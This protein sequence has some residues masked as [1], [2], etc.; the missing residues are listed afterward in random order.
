[1]DTT[2]RLADRLTESEPRGADP[3]ASAKLRRL[4]LR[5]RTAAVT[6]VAAQWATAV[7]R[8]ARFPEEAFAELRKQRL[9]GIMI[10]PDLG[11]EGASLSEIVDVCYQLGQACSST[12]MIFAM[13][14]ACLACLLRHGHDH[15]WH[16]TLLRRVAGDQLLLASSTTEGQGGGNVRASAAPVEHTD[17]GIRLERAATVVSYGERADAILT[18]ARRSAE[19][20]ASDQV[21]VAFLKEDYTLEPLVGWDSLGMRGT[22]SSGFRLIANGKA[23]QI[24]PEP[25]DRIHPQ[26]M[27][28]VSHLAWAGTWAGIAA[29]AVERA[30]AFVRHAARHSGGNMPPGAAHFTKAT[31]SLR[32]LRGLIASSLRAYEEIAD[33]GKSLASLDFQAVMNL[34][35]VEASELAVSIV[36]TTMKVC[37]LSGYRNDTEFSVGRALRDVL[38]SPIMISNDR[39]LGNLAGTMLMT[40]VPAGIE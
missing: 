9:M 19:A 40:P 14:Q 21:L 25:Y 32:T 34:T 22:C 23:E 26:S 10:P 16:R 29:G 20:A 28:P 12:S 11:G 38:S 8:E 27:V 36:L 3:D 39:I 4:D 6:A 13:H 37:G 15:A 5:A 1:M 18:T 2:S 33:D 24:L 7:D 17:T 35:K 30:R 31:A